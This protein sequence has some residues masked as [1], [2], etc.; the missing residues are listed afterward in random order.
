MK[1]SLDKIKIEDELL[2]KENITL[3][4]QIQNLNEQKWR[5]PNQVNKNINNWS[6][7]KN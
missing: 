3:R 5:N 2:Q 1:K 6:F 7:I 4:S